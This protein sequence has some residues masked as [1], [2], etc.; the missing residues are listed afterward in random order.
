MSCISFSFFYE[1]EKRM[2]KLKIQSKDLLNM[3]ILANYLNFV[4]HIEV[5]TKF[6]H[7]ILNFVFQ[8]IKNTKWHFG[9][10]DLAAMKIKRDF[11]FQ[12]NLGPKIT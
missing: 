1:N 10:T 3:K 4:F 6:N 11:N 12:N 9:Y 2:R 5:K 8:F 7:K